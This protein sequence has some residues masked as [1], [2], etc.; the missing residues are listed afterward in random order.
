MLIKNKHFQSLWFNDEK[1]SISIIDQRNLPFKFETLEIRD[2]DEIKTIIKEMYVRGAPLIGVTASYGMYLAA[3]EALSQQNPKAYFQK[4][5]D[6][7]KEHD[8]LL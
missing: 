4:K 3:K 5:A 8:L 1:Q 6:E 7:I 2:T